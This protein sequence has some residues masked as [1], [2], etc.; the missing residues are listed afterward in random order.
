MSNWNASNYRQRKSQRLVQVK[1]EWITNP[2]TGEQFY[3]RNSRALMSSVLA[4]YMPSALT[5]A[6]VE[7]WKEKGVAGLEGIGNS[8]DVASVVASLTPE[9]IEAGNRNMQRLSGIIQQCCVIPLLSNEN[10]ETMEF[11]P[12]WM[13]AAKQGLDEKDP[14]FDLATFNPKD[15]VLD[16]QELEDKDSSFLFR[17]ASGLV[18]SVNTKG[19]GVMQVDDISRFRKKPGRKSR[20]S[21]D[22]PQVRETA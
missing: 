22:Q 11:S 5:E 18:G 8:T 16:P 13:A 3:L 10:P 7:A 20:V 19:G 1:P 21:N 4:G 15:L 2:D 17:W 14:E 6:A 12:E 9:Q